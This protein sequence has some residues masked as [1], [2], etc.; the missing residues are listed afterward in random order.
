MKASKIRSFRKTLRRFERSLT[1]QLK[2]NSFCGGVTMAQ[3]H[4]LLEIED[5]GKT[6]PGRLAKSIGLDKSTL[7]RTIDGLVNIGLVERTP[8][9]SDRRSIHISLT[10][11]G[12]NTSN[13]INL[14]NDDYYG[15]VFQIIQEE[16]REQVLE[17]FRLLVKA[18]DSQ[19]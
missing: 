12:K 6:T 14:S 19:E 1:A 15:R 5:Q 3:C 4:A 11:R 17:C 9:R 16:K 10:D 2:D 8:H 18:M 7:S 13:L